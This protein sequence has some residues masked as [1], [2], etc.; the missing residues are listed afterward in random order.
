MDYDNDCIFRGI[1]RQACEICANIASRDSR[2]V[3]TLIGAGIFKALIEV[4]RHGDFDNREEAL[5]VYAKV[6]FVTTV[7]QVLYLTSVGCVAPL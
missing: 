6:K 7:D 4:I 5:E 2:Y 1:F 3:Q